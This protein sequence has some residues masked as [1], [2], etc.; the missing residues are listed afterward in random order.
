MKKKLLLPAVRL[1]CPYRLYPLRY[2]K[3]NE[4][5]IKHTRLLIIIIYQRSN[6]FNISLICCII[7]PWKEFVFVII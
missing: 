6:M 3:V 5:M 4:G 7:I 1:S 2:R